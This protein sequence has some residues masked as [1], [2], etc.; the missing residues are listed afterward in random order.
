[1]LVS[2]RETARP[3]RE[4]GISTIYIDNNR[5]SHF[6]PLR[7]S[8]RIYFVLLSDSWRRRSRRRDRQSGVHP[9]A[10]LVAGGTVLPV[11]GAPRVGHVP[12][13]G[14]QVRRVSLEGSHQ[15]GAAQILPVGAGFGALSYVLNQSI[16]AL[17]DLGIVPAK[18]C[19]ETALF[20]LS[21]VVQ[22]DFV[23]GQKRDSEA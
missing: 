23:F 21:F 4:V 9:G 20:F 5:S 17:T 16:V 13:H 15:R 18:L 22:R 19:A 7:D 1:M 8:M 6:N 10:A 3:V 11:S 12:V 2:C 14:R